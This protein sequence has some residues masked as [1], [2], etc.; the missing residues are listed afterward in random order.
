MSK[1]LMWFNTYN[2]FDSCKNLFNDIKKY[3]K[4]HEIDLFIIN[5]GSSQDYSSLTPYI[6]YYIS[7]PNPH[8]KEKYW[9]VINAGISTIKKIKKKYD[10]YVKTDD[11]MRLAPNFFNIITKLVKNMKDSDWATIDILSAKRQRGKT[12]L[13]NRA[14]IVKNFYK[15]YRTQW[16]DMNFIFDLAKMPCP[17]GPCKSGKV[18][19]GVG[20]WLTRYFNQRGFN[21]YQ[22]PQ[23]LVLHGNVDSKMH[24]K[25]RKKNPL[26]TK[27]NK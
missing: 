12:L 7:Y 19:S 5:D 10:I 16:V 8:G 21:L 13:G 1:I 6:K 3:K 11:D 2:R 27:V 22:S 9:K 17:I 24:F 14:E 25:E 26:I 15:Y 4:N 23:S 20:L 18:T